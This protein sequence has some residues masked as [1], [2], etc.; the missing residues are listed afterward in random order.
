MASH[1]CKAR[2][3][4]PR[5]AT[6]WSLAIWAGLWTAINQHNSTVNLWCASHL[7]GCHSSTHPRACA[8]DCGHQ[9]PL[10]SQ[11][12]STIHDVPPNRGAWM[13]TVTRPGPHPISFAEQLAD[14]HS[15]VYTGITSGLQSGKSLG[16]L[17]RIRCRSEACVILTGRQASDPSEQPAQQHTA[18]LNLSSTN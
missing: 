10:S 5:L 3:H 2:R 14:S 7:H 18:F 16:V 9:H 17:Q 4:A 11:F 8:G 6:T 13:R 12:R 15:S 1:K